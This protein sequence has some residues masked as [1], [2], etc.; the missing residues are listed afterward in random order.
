MSSVHNVSALNV[1]GS[2]KL[3][4][5]CGFAS[6]VGALFEN[7]LLGES[8]VKSLDKAHLNTRVLATI[9][10]YLRILKSENNQ[11][12]LN[13]IIKFTQAFPGYETFSIDAYITKIESVVSDPSNI[14]QDFSIAM[15]P[16]P[17]A[18]FIRRNGLKTVLIRGSTPALKSNVI[19]GLGDGTKTDKW[20]GL[21]HWV[22]CNHG[23][24]IYNYGEA[25]G[26]D[27]A[28]SK[29]A[30]F[31]PGTSWSVVYQMPLEK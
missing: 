14:N 1:S 26:S 11:Q 19:L 2:G 23:G 16:N 13:E 21:K 18:D 10:T 12:Y 22:Y 8:A 3:G 4:G 17:V 15:P 5:I 9:V 31:F 29:M 7:G 30:D 24:T 20:D 25:Y 28:I 6:T 27:Q